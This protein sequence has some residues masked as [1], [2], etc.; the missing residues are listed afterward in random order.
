LKKRAAIILHVLSAML[1][2]SACGITQELEQASTT[3]SALKELLHMQTSQ[4]QELQ[5]DVQD[6]WRAFDS[7]DLNNVKGEN[8]FNQEKGELFENMERRTEQ[9]QQITDTQKEI[10]AVQ[11]QLKGIHKKEAVDVDNEKLQL[12]IN[13]L[14]I[15]KND[16]ESLSLYLTS[17]FEQEEALYSQLPVENLSSQ[18][19]IL[20][21]T[22]GAIML[23]S[24][25]SIANIDYTL[26]LIDTFT[27]SQNKAAASQ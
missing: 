12:I 2:L 23:V 5:E 3:V 13:S 14:D 19:S 22:F 9:L 21:R 4:L 7:D 25:E 16:F 18:Q 27:A 8:L 24:D 10:D 20:N 26:G 6:I 1:F 15:L 17:S 11:R